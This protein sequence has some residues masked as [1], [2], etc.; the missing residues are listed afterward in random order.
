MGPPDARR[1][2]VRHVLVAVW[3]SRLAR[4]AAVVVVASAVAVAMA[5]SLMYSR[6]RSTTCQPVEVVDISIDQLIALK[7]R[8]EAYQV[9]PFNNELALTGDEISFLLRGSVDFEIRLWF[10]EGKV[11]ALAAVPREGGCYNIEF[12]GRVEVDDGT[13]IIAPQDVTVG[14]MDFAPW[15]AGRVYSLLPEDFEDPLVVEQ[16]HNTMRVEVRGSQLYIQVDDPWR[17]PW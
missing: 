3:R 8:K 10:E 4:L 6:A 12:F 11:R 17:M 9:D 13:V 1:T 14:D 5:V 7:R 2:Y 16:L 15:V